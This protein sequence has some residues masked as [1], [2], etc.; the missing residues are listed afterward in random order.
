MIGTDKD[1]ITATVTDYMK[2][3]R[4]GSGERIAKAFYSSVNL[5]P[6]DGEGNLVLTPRSALEALADSGTLPPNSGEIQHVEINNDMAFGK[7]KIDLPT[8][9]D[10]DVPTLL[11]LNAGWKIVSKTYTTLMK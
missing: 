10:Y 2:G 4:K 7:V 9:N 3:F 8:L 1:Q 5:N 6:V 11:R